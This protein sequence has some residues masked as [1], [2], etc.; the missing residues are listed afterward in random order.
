MQGC[1]AGIVVLQLSMKCT[2]PTASLY[3]RSARPDIPRAVFLYFSLASIIHRSFLMQFFY[4]DWIN[5]K[6]RVPVMGK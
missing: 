6:Q 1:K 4:H 5:V 3:V 2:S